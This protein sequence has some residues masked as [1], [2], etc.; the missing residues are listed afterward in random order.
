MFS[1]F[2]GILGMSEGVEII[3]AKGGM[4]LK[5]EVHLRTYTWIV[6]IWE[7][8]TFQEEQ[9]DGWTLQFRVNINILKNERVNFFT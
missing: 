6:D 7:I 4:C 5:H 1:L 9:K 2:C 3:K 8:M